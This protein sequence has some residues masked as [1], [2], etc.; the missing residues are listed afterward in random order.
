MVKS[1]VRFKTF[2][3]DLDTDEAAN[4]SVDGFVHYTMMVSDNIMAARMR[5]LLVIYDLEP[6]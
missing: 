1:A 5:C 3:C 2:Y 6:P 4:I